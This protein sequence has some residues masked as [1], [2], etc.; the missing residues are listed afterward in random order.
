MPRIATALTFADRLGAWK[1]RRGV[2]LTNY[3]VP[4]GLYAIGSPTP[5]A[6]VLVTAN[7]KMSY[8]ILRSAAVFSGSG[9]HH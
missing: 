5:D 2:G 3:L 6:P 7:Y 9:T 8:D 1:A 4:P